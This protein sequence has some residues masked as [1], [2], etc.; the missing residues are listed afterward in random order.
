MLNDDSNTSPML[1]PIPENHSVASVLPD[2]EDDYM[3]Q[4]SSD[5]K[6]RASPVKKPN[7]GGRILFP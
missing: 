3:M 4:N 7:L 2:P 6:I 1:L 5:E